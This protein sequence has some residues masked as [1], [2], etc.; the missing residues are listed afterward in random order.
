GGDNAQPQ[1]GAAGDLAATLGDAQ[2]AAQLAQRG[3]LRLRRGIY[4]DL[5]GPRGLTHVLGIED[6]ED[7]LTLP[8]AS[9]Y[10]TPKGRQL[11]HRPEGALRLGGAD[12]D[13]DVAR[14]QRLL[15]ALRKLLA[16]G[17]LLCVE[18]VINAPGIERGQ[19]RNAA[20]AVRVGVA[21]EDLVVAGHRLLL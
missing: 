2:H 8:A 20:R 1:R 10:K 12:A 6:Q 15:Q 11:L 9:A 4:D 13:E 17:Q 7:N 3:G 21:D 18:P 14:G 5:A 16:G 19:Q